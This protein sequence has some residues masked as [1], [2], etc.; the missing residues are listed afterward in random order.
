MADELNLVKALE[1]YN[2]LLTMMDKKGWHYTKIEEKLM[3][4]SGVKTEDIPVSF[5]VVVNPRNEVVQ[6]LSKLP[7]DVPEDKRIDLA[8][9]V[10]VANYQL[11]DGCF[12]YDCRDGSLIFRLTSSYRGSQLSEDVFE[13]MIYC[14]AST[15]DAFNDK[16]FLL[17][18]G[19]LTL[20]QFMEMHKN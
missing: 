7:F 11:V 10:C 14:A 13:Y 2:T 20:Q 18:K 4:E 6:F 5:Y 17:A 15:V 1:V 12:D 16:F 19:E 3:I 9:A 8:I